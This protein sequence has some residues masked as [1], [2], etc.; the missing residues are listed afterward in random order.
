M[1]ENFIL[2]RLHFDQFLG[3]F[4]IL[5]LSSIVVADVLIV[6]SYSG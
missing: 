3:R 1:L 6:D 5:C 2:F 4:M